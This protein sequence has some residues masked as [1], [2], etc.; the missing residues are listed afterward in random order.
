MEFT[1]IEYF[2]ARVM[3][4]FADYNIR[5]VLRPIISFSYYQYFG[6]MN[7]KGEIAVKPKCFFAR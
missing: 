7:K 5:E 6:L 4:D 1:N 2:I 3:I